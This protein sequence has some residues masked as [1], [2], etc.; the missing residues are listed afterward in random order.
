[1]SNS[2]MLATRSAGGEGRDPD[3]RPLLPPV[4]LA[5]SAMEPGIRPSV[6]VFRKVEVHGSSADFVDT[7]WASWSNNEEL[8]R[9]IEGIPGGR[10]LWLW[11]CSSLALRV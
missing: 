7:S 6:L 5:S 10:F 4:A 2:T 1:M 11:M 8:L 3:R 9:T